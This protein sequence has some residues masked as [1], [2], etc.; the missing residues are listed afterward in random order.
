MVLKSPWYLIRIGC[1]VAFMVQTTTLIV[2]MIN[3]KETL[4]K[5]QIMNF[6]KIDFPLTFK[7]CIT[8]GF[9]TTELKALGY[10]NILGYFEGRSRFNTSIIGW[11]GH[12]VDGQ[13]VSNISG[14]ILDIILRKG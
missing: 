4:I 3:P 2:N 11:A 6:D 8:P 10:E 12:T 5:T 14:I 13:V 9:N 1:L 7:I